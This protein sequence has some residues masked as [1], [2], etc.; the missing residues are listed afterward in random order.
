ME[1][2]KK[3]DLLKMKRDIEAMLS[4]DKSED[5]LQIN[6]FVKKPKAIEGNKWLF[7]FQDTEFL[8]SRTLSPSACKIIMLFRA[9]CKYENKVDYSAKQIEKISGISK[10]ATYRALKELKDV[11]IIMEFK[12]EIDERRKVYYI[13]PESQWK[14]KMANKTGI[15]AIFDAKGKFEDFR[16]ETNPNQLDLLDQI[17]EIGMDE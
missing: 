10:S 17:K 8:L 2:L 7:L 16:T 3:S 4:S 14:G 12:D 1:N 11:G 5:D 15:K 9:I 6:V 13:N